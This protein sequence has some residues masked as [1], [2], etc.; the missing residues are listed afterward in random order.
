MLKTGP[1]L[2]VVIY[3]NADISS[4][5]DFLHNEILDFLFAKGVAGATLMRAEAGFGSHHRVHMKGTPG[6]EGKHLPLRLEFVDQEDVVKEILA[7]LL[8][9]VTDG[10]VEVQQTTI[11]K[12]ANLIHGERG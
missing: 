3:L 6:G 2:R 8:E 1:A 12:V 10:M 5:H 7:E 11:L 4:R 9:L